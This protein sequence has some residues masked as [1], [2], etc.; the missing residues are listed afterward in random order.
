MVRAAASAV[1]AEELFDAGWS[2]SPAI[3]VEHRESE[4]EHVKKARRVAS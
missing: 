2:S 3:W 1:S 4:E